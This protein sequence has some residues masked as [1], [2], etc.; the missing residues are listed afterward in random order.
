MKWITILV[1]LLSIQ[2][3]VAQ[4]NNISQV[5]VSDNGDGTYK[6]PIIHSDYSD[7]DVIRVGDDYYLT[8]SSF[9]AVPALQILHSN[10]LVN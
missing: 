5:W 1:L 9:E 2:L 10:D 3:A 4:K 8:A 6:N 7:P